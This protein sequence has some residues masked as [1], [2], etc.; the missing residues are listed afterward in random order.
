MTNYMD[1]ANIYTALSVAHKRITVPYVVVKHIDS[2]RK[3][4]RFIKQAINNI[5]HS[6]T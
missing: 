6:C 1:K 4:L 5:C 2:M 3:K